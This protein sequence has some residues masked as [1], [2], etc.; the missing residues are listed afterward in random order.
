M[1]NRENLLLTGKGGAS[2]FCPLKSSGITRF[3]TQTML[4][5]EARHTASDL[6]VTPI[7]DV[8]GRMKVKANTGTAAAAGVVAGARK[9]HPGVL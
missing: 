2:V 6:G 3:L 7:S 9:S 4:R 8:N 5:R 1:P